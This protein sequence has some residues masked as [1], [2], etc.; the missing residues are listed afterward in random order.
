M[1]HEVRCL[2]Q[3]TRSFQSNAL[4]IETPIRTVVHKDTVMCLNKIFQF[5]KLYENNWN[6]LDDPWKLQCVGQNVECAA[7]RL[8]KVCACKCEYMH[9]FTHTARHSVREA[10]SSG[11][12]LG[13][14]EVLAAPGQGF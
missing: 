4:N 3:R 11:N 1:G 10:T 2:R 8:F 9:L 14:A 7:I 13:D 12:L 6:I 5:H